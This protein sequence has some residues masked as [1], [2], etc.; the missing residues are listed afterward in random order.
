MSV[1]LLVRQQANRLF[2]PAHADEIIA[3]LDRSDLPL[4]YISSDRVHLAVLILSQGDMEQFRIA[5]R[6]AKQDCRDT[7]VAAGLAGD[8]WPAVLKLKGIEI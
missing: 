4:G 7:L 2:G 6:E 5:L 8:N 3:A 1:S